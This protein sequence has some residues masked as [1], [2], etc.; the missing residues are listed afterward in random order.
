MKDCKPAQWKKG[1][2]DK[3][4]MDTHHHHH[5][6]IHSRNCQ[7]NNKLQQDPPLRSQELRKRDYNKEKDLYH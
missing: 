6:Q 4:G 3:E 1:A 2:A 7:K 5:H